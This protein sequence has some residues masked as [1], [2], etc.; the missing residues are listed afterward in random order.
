MSRTKY[1]AVV[2]CLSALFLVVLCGCG[3]GGSTSSFPTGSVQLS[4]KAAGGGAG[5]VSSSPSG[6]NCGQACSAS[7]SSGTQVTLTASPT[8]N[9]FFSGWS[10]ACSGAGVCKM[11]LTQ[12]ISVI[13][14][15]STSPTLTVALAG[16]GKGSVASTPSGI[17]C[18][19][20]CSATF[21]PST[22]VTLTATAAANSSFAGWGGACSGTNP[23]CTVTLNASQQ[24]TANFNAANAPMLSV[25][26]GGTG[27]GTVTSAP[28]GISCQ[29]SCTATFNAGTKVTLTEAPAAN[30]SFAGWGGACSGTQLH[31]H[32]DAR[33]EPA[34]DGELYRNPERACINR[35]SRRNRQRCRDQQSCR[36]QLSTHLQFR[37]FRLKLG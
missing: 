2:C 29:P 25:T 20:T 28:S 22:Q 17:S 36:N 8:T 1:Q 10:G 4:V 11:T 12:N 31:L 13:A 6:I 33:G 32:R 27:T 19:Q 35:D 34:G 30:S 5:M 9:S 3:G 16:T 24:V 21:D 37:A 26:L 18:G 14:N 15:F 7:F 23:T